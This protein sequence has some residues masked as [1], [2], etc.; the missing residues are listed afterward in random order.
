MRPGWRRSREV[1]SAAI[2]YPMLSGDCPRCGQKKVTFDLRGTFAIRSDAGAEQFETFLLCRHC[3]RTS[4][5]LLEPSAFAPS[6]GPTALQGNFVNHAYKLKNW[7]FEVPGRRKAPDYVPEEIVRI[8]DEAAI[9]GAVHAWDA[10]GTMFRKVVDAATRSITPPPTEAV[11]LKPKNWKTYKDL[12]LRLDWL[13]DN[14][15]LSP[16]LKDV[17]S[18]IHEDGNDAA[19]ALA[20]IGKNEAEDLADFTELVLETLY[21]LPGQIAANRERRDR[22]RGLPTTNAA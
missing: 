10:A 5:G 15:L 11:S 7:I 13:F 20:G 18:C 14:G 16:M 21:T 19:H 9:C 6:G 17:S 22:R 12:R 4:L 8:F 1:S 3:F 2:Q